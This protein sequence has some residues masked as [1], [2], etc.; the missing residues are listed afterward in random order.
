MWPGYEANSEQNCLLSMTKGPS[1]HVTPS[2]G[3]NTTMVQEEHV[4]MT[5]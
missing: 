4:H 3:Y 2:D 5:G 1:H